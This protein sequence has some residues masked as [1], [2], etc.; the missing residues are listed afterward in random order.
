MAWTDSEKEYKKIGKNTKK[1]DKM[2]DKEYK[3]II[4]KWEKWN[5]V[6]SVGN[7]YFI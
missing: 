5:V 6:K 2:A 1:M 3:R 7:L 4:K